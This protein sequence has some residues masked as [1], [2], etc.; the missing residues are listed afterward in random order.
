MGYKTKVEGSLLLFELI[1]EFSIYDVL[2]AKNEILENFTTLEALTLN[3]SKL[4]SIDTAGIQLIIS[5]IKT[6]RAKKIIIKIEDQAKVTEY[7]DY[8]GDNLGPFLNE[9]ISNNA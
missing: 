2:A 6:C 9:S 8:L 5:I 7:L 3:F 1:E 4:N